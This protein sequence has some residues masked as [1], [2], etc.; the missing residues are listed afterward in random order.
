M[1]RLA[2]HASRLSR[3]TAVGS[4]E[5]E[6]T[7]RNGAQSAG[8][9]GSPPPAA[10][11]LPALSAGPGPAPASG[12]QTRGAAF[13]QQA[14]LL[15]AANARWISTTQQCSAILPDYG[16]HTRH[17]GAC[18]FLCTG[19]RRRLSGTAVRASL[20][21]LN[22]DSGLNASKPAAK[23]QAWFNQDTS[24]NSAPMVAVMVGRDDAAEQCRRAA[25]DIRDEAVGCAPR[26]PVDAVAAPCVRTEGRRTGQD[27]R[28]ATASVPLLNRTQ[29]A[30]GLHSMWAL[31]QQKQ[32]RTHRSPAPP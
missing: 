27:T 13:A 23:Q 15:A 18:D 20:L 2:P 4:G 12:R 17:S 31:C 1:S 25:A 7:L 32:A 26:R 11:T 22:L 21:F 5:A 10:C 28:W 6:A 29:D 16:V 14:P 9:G 8:A 24:L 30:A 3:L 19:V